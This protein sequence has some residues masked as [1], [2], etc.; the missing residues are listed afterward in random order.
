M[1]DNAALVPEPHY[2]YADYRAWDLKE[3]ERYELI[4]G[5]PCAMSAPS[6]RHQA[7]LVALAAA[8]YNFFREGPCRVRPAPYD[9]R[10][11]Y[12]PDGTDDTVVQPDLS[13]VCSEERRGPEGCRGAPDLVVEILSSSNTAIEM[14]RKFN[15]YRQAAVREYWVVSPEEKTIHA[16][17][18]QGERVTNRVYGGAAGFAADP[19]AGTAAPEIFPGLEIELE[20]VFAE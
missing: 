14:I 10:L 6:D 13:V 20:P 11:F 2:T 5:I 15:L 3:G 16:Y 4:D 9:V 7:V 8:F 17:C 12:R 1:A 18:F 19:A